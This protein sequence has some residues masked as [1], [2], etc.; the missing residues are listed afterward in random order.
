MKTSAPCIGFQ[1]T[2]SCWATS[3]I[4]SK[5]FTNVAETHAS[6][7]LRG[8]GQSPEAKGSWIRSALEEEN[9]EKFRSMLPEFLKPD[10]EEIIKILTS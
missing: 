1:P 6:E 9:V 10:A 3:P 2:N 5:Y 8:V 7:F 4:A